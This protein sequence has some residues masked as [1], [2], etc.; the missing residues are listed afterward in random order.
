[1]IVDRRSVITGLVATAAFPIVPARA[2]FFGLV[3]ARFFAGLIFDIARA[4]FIQLASDFIVQQLKSGVRRSSFAALG[5]ASDYSS[6]SYRSE[7][8]QAAI[9]IAGL[10]DYR[11]GEAKRIEA[12]LAAADSTTLERLEGTRKVLYDRKVEASFSCGGDEA[13][14]RVRSDEP[15]HRLLAVRYI[16]GNDEVAQRLFREMV[17]SLGSTVFRQ[18]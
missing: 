14:R 12:Y 2:G 8:Y 4:V 10:T 9:A 11:I 1:M 17:D 7:N 18:V 16:A 13:S 6:A 3:P 5:E 15:L